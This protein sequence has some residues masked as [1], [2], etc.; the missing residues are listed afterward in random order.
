MS[1]LI[2]TTIRSNP[3]Q[4]KNEQRSITIRTDPTIQD[5]S[6]A[7]EYFKNW[8]NSISSDESDS[9]KKHKSELNKHLEVLI[10]SAE[11]QVDKI[12]LSYTE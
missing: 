8:N 11:K 7:I 10:W 4:I 5:I 2:G 12:M 1:T 6:D 3:L 9:Y